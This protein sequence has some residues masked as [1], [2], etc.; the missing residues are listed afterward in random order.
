MVWSA[1]VSTSVNKDKC[2]WSKWIP[3]YLLSWPTSE[4]IDAVQ[5]L[6]H[7]QRLSEFR[8]DSCNVSCSEEP[9]LL[10]L[11][12]IV[13]L[14]TTIILVVSQILRICVL[15]A[16]PCVKHAL[17]AIRVENQNDICSNFFRDQE[18][19]SDWRSSSVMLAI[20]TNGAMLGTRPDVPATIPASSS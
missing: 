12:D 4:I 17:K 7:G 11:L 3:A 13:I 18:K 14:T 20:C 19:D 9:R 6:W 16:G 8:P 5:F 1:T 10:Q 15:R 2:Q